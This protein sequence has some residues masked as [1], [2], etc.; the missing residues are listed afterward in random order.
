M[1]NVCVY[2]GSNPGVDAVYA[3]TARKLGQEIARRRLGLVYGGSNMGLMGC[4][5]NAVL[6]S[7]G[8]AIGV[9][10]RG[11]FRGEMAHTG[12]SQFY[13][14]ADMHERKA[15]MAELSDAFI[16]LP[17]GYGT[18]EEL[19]EAVSWCQLGIHQKPVGIL[20][21]NGYYT[22]L[23]Q[24]IGNA[25]SAGFMPSSHADLLVSD[26]DPARL[27]DKLAAY[28]RPELSNKWGQKD[29]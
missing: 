21:V 19:F 26:S 20:N 16:A 17:G 23:L 15:K 25:V 28:Q 8:T 27:L 13:E 1:N 9:M 14:V 29:E 18:W 4:T 5:A 2:A 11:L 10:P 12:L 3:E 22:P 24:M 6:E 7:G